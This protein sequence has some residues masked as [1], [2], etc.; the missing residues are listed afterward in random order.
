MPP[1][2]TNDNQLT[3]L[4][5]AQQD[6]E[7]TDDAT[8]PDWDALG[9]TSPEEAMLPIEGEPLP[10]IEKEKANETNEPDNKDDSADDDTSSAPAADSGDSIKPDED[11]VL[12]VEEYSDRMIEVEINGEVRLVPASEMFDKY[13][14]A[15]QQPSTPP[16]ATYTDADVRRVLEEQRQQWLQEQQQQ[17]ADEIDDYDPMD[18]IDLEGS[19]YDRDDPL[20]KAWAEDRRR[21]RQV[22]QDQEWAAYEQQRNA[23]IQQFAQ[24]YPDEPVMDIVNY[25]DKHGLQDLDV[26]RKAFIYDNPTHRPTSAYKRSP[27]TAEQLQE[28]KDAARKASQKIHQNQNKTAAREADT[29]LKPPGMHASEEE[30]QAYLSALYPDIPDY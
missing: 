10:T 30:K 2:D 1:E 24:A 20:V 13:V 19:L 12:S 16:A 18:D 15:Q 4:E 26:A 25:A 5:Q 29:A 14:D 11:N 27:L 9:L 8:P 22:E 6:W 21:L 7:S 28:R 3:P 23:A 17:P